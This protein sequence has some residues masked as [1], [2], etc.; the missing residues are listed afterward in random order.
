MLVRPQITNFRM[1]VR[2]DCTLSACSPLP[3]SKKALAHWLSLGWGG[4]G[5][6]LDRHLPPPLVAS[7][8]NQPCL[9]IGFEQQEAG[10]GVS[11][12]IKNLWFTDELEVAISSVQFSRSV[13]S[14]S[15]WLHGLQHARLPCLSPTSRIYSNSYP[16]SHWCHPTISSSVVPFSSCL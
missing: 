16:L 4:G 10:S 6:P 15:L 12:T 14:N 1:T 5:R 8:Q 3:L 7:I 13:V 11:N 2:A 9:S